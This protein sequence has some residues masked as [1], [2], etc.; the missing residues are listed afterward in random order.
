MK[1]IFIVTIFAIILSIFCIAQ[2]YDQKYNV[3]LKEYSIYFPISKSWMVWENIPDRN[4]YK[5]QFGYIQK[6]DGYLDRWAWIE[7]SIRKD[8]QNNKL[9]NFLLDTNDYSYDFYGA[10]TTPEE[11]PFSIKSNKYKIRLFELHKIEDIKM[12]NEYEL[13]AVVDCG[14][15]NLLEFKLLCID[16]EESYTMIQDFY[17]GILEMKIMKKEDYG[18]K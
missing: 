18:T 16:K 11:I 13:V 8:N 4:N 10:A 1:K 7:I 15:S 17:M 5:A 2:D 6:I 3:D 9:N 12:E 14:Y